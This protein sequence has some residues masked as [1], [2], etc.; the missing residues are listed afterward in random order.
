MQVHS[1]RVPVVTRQVTLVCGPPC[2]GK[3]RY[4]AEHAQPGD[5]IVCLDLLAQQAGSPVE[6][7]HDGRFY[8]R[9]QREYTRLCR[10]IRQQPEVT[11]WVVR[12][13][14]EPHTRRL[15]ALEVD[16]TET[17]VLFPPIEAALERARERGGDY[18]RTAVAVQRW[19]RRYRPDPSDL[20]LT[21]SRSAL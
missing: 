21:E 18:A 9:A 10:L 8:G 7:S 20:V 1:G 16:A 3:S 6:H 15:L 12:C 11:G 2:G 14:P 19:Y 5:V 17:V 4:V 13:A